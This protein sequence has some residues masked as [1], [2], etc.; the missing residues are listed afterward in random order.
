VTAVAFEAERW[1]ADKGRPVASMETLDALG[2]LAIVRVSFTDGGDS[3][4]TL[5]PERPEWEALVAGARE[6][7]VY[8][9]PAP[10]GV[11]EQLRVDQS[12]S[13]WRVGSTYVKCYRRL[14]VG[15]HPEVELLQTLGEHSFVHAPGYRGV[16]RWRSPAGEDVALA[17]LA[18]FVE[19]GAEGWEWAAELARA[20]DASFARELGAVAR[21]LHE[22]LA[23]ALGTHAATAADSEAWRR[24]ADEQLTRALT[25]V[26]E[27]REHQARARR[28]LARLATPVEA[29]LVARIHGDLHVGQFLRAGDRLVMVDFEGQP[30][31]SADERR[32]PDTPLRDLASLSRSLDHCGRY[33]IRRRG[34][35]PRRTEGWIAEARARLL[36]G[37]GDC[38]RRLLRALE[39]ERAIYEFTY[40]AT[41]LPEWMYAPS[42]GLDALLREAEE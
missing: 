23:A 6:P 25:L 32:L 19:D 31:K 3:L 40:A 24:K 11:E 8:D 15:P 21:R 36:M 14:T 27:L 16:L 41:H 37:Y 38:D 30:G 20:G 10:S 22:T 33:A 29:P 12:H 34:A 5:V 7:F 35:D 2:R 17:V 13:S 39:W 28:E 4:Y 9:G 18:E 42:G 26:P 1:Y